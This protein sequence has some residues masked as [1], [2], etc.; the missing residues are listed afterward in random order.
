MI[1]VIYYWITSYSE[2]SFL[3]RANENSNDLLPDPTKRFL[4]WWCTENYNFQ[5]YFHFSSGFFTEINAWYLKTQSIFTLEFLASSK[6]ILIV[7]YDALLCIAKRDIYMNLKM[8]NH[9]TVTKKLV[10]IMDL[11]TMNKETSIVCRQQIKLVRFTIA[12]S[13]SSWDAHFE[14]RNDYFRSVATTNFKLWVL[15]K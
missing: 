11:A 2:I 8:S 5:N 6:A 3:L 12:T 7:L 10:C 1:A 9:Q 14:Q 4:G 15:W 13:N